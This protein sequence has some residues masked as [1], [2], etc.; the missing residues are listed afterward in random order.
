MKTIKFRYKQK[1]NKTI[2]GLIISIESVLHIKENMQ[3]QR[4]KI[5]D[6][7]IIQA[8]IINGHSK[9]FIG[10]DKAITVK[11]KIENNYII[12]ELGEAKWI[13][14]GIKEN[15]AEILSMIVFPLTITSSIGTYKQDKLP[16]TIKETADNYMEEDGEFV[17]ESVSSQNEPTLLKK[18]SN[19][20]E[21]QKSVIRLA[22]K[23]AKEIGKIIGKL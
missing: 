5:E 22:P 14:K 13:D 9:S 23:I 20:H 15:V 16:E 4:L 3:T 7:E 21:I 8:R 2:D 19:N 17:V 18:I 11:V 12:I 1:N 10:L 6:V